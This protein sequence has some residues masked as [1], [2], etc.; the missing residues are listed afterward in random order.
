LVKQEA[1]S[2]GRFIREVLE[3]Q[4][5]IPFRQITNDTAFNKFTGSKRPDILISEV[6]YDLKEK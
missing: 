3:T 5:D 4:L 2:V 1:L 6:E